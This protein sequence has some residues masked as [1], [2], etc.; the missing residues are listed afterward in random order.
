MWNKSINT[1]GFKDYKTED[2]LFIAWGFAKS[3]RGV[4]V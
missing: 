2:L 1:V 4:Y 3:N